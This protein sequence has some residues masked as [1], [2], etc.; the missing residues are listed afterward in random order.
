V[1]I[2]LFQSKETIRL[3]IEDDG[4]GIPKNKIN[5]INSFG[6]TGITERAEMLNGSLKISGDK[7][8]KIEVVIPFYK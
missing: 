6:I 1:N 8:T 3:L 2:V 5:H 7:G 4:I